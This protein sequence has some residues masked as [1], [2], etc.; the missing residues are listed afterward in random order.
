M[1]YTS[2]MWQSRKLKFSNY[3]TLSVKAARATMQMFLS[4]YESDRVNKQ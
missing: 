4:L 3:A 2:I 1:F